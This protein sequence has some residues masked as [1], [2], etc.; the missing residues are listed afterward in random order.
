M[1]INELS[2][3]GLGIEINDID[4]KKPLNKKDV[5]TIRD[6]WLNFSVAIFPNQK[7]S[8]NEFENFSLSFGDFGDDWRC[9]CFGNI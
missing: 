6:L 9:S 5:S 4:L 7:L 2:D 1:K 3:S 8:H